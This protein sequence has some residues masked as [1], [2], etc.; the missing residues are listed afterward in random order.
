VA[1]VGEPPTDSE[2]DQV[3]VLLGREPVGDY[4]VS[5]RRAN[6]DVAVIGNAPLMSDGTPMPTMYWLVDRMLVAEVSRLEADGAVDRIEAEIGLE[7]MAEVHDV[8]RRERDALLP[9]DHAGPAPAGGVGGT[10]R[11]LKC[12]HAHLAWWLVGGND[13]AGSRVADMLLERGVDLPERAT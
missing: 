1:L 6:G 8:H 11:G 2:H 12:L 7:A 5:L 4:V 13:P 3:V 9:R 10:R